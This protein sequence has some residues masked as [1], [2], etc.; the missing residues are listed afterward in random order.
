M[1]RYLTEIPSFFCLHVLLYNNNYNLC[2]HNNYNNK[3]Q[4]CDVVEF[5]GAKH[6]ENCAPIGYY[7]AN[8]GKFLTTFRGNLSVPSWWVK[9]TG[10]TGCPE[11]S[12]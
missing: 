2:Q 5:L 8:S 4:Y 1:I 12:L 9:K 3:Y 10:R 6:N 7:A 11:T